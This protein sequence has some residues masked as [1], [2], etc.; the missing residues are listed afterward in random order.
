MFDEHSDFYH[1]VHS[2]SLSYPS[3]T[4]NNFISSCKILIEKQYS[5]RSIMDAIVLFYFILQ[6]TV[7]I[8]DSQYSNY[9]VKFINAMI[10]TAH[11]LIHD[12]NYCNNYPEWLKLIGVDILTITIRTFDTNNMVL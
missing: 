5:S 6:N 11:R 3:D 8:F 2:I 10:P 1:E 7:I 9:F 12:I 4:F